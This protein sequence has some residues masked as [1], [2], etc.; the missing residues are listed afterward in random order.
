MTVPEE[1]AEPTAP[2]PGRADDGTLFEP[3]GPSDEE[4]HGRL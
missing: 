2:P 4:A 1:A 3:A